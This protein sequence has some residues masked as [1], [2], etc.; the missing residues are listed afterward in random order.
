MKT[1]APRASLRSFAKLG[2]AGL[3]AS[4]AVP[5]FAQ[6]TPPA[7]ATPATPAASAPASPSDDDVLQLDKFV[8]TG[9]S[10]PTE[11]LDSPVVVT[12]FSESY[13]K[14]LNPQSITELAWSIPGF[15]PEDSGGDVG[16]NIAPRGF[17]LSTQME[18]T[19]IQRDGMAVFY[20]QD[21]LFTQSDRF[22]RTS[23]FVQE[24][25]AVRS[26]PS[27][28]FMGSAPAGI[29][30]LISREGG[31]TT[32]GDL[33]F[34]TNTNNRFGFDGWVSGSFDA[35]TTYALGGWYRSD[36]S[37]RD[38]GFTANQGGELNAALKR[39]FQHGRGSFK[40]DLNYQNDE[41][42]FFL[43]M[44]L[45][46]TTS[47]PRTIPG[48]P[49]LKDGT[50]G[51]SS[52]GR[53]LRLANTPSG[54]L[55]FDLQNG[56]SAKVFYV[57]TEFTY[58]LGGGWTVKNQNRYSD[59]E[60]GFDAIINV[61]NARPLT[62]IA[63]E[64]YNSAPARFAGAKNDAGKLFF[65]V[66]ETSSGAV[67][68]NQDS[69]GALNTNGFGIDGGWFHRTLDATN[70]QNDFRLQ[71]TVGDLN[72]TFGVFFSDVDGQVIDHRLDTLQTVSPRPVRADI[73]FLRPDGAALTDDPATAVRE[74]GT[75][76]F[77][78]LLGGP[79]GFGNAIYNERNLAL[80]TDWNYKLGRFNLNLGARWEQLDADGAIE[81]Q[82]S[83][84]LS[85]DGT[86]ND[87]GN[88]ALTN[89]PFG[90]GKFRD[91]DLSYDR[92]A[93]TAAANY[94]LTD[95][96]AVFARYA[97]GFRMPD[98]DKFMAIGGFD[99]STPAGA[100]AIRDFNNSKRPETK[101]AETNIVDVGFKYRSR[102]L[103]TSI[104]GFYAEAKNLFFNVPTVV[105]GQIVQRQAFRNT[106]TYGG[107]AEVS[108][109]PTAGWN[110]SFNATWQDP[111]FKSTPPQEA[112][113]ASGQTVRVNLNGNVPVRTSKFF[114][115][116][117]TSYTF[118][119]SS[120]GTPTIYASVSHT[121]KRYADDANTAALSNYQLVGAGIS[122]ET[123]RGLYFRAD[124]HNL[125]ESKGLSEGDPRAGETIFGG[126]ATFNARAV[127]PRVFTFR[128]GYR[129]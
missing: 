124:V 85:N 41:A 117:R 103:S 116:A 49:S 32:H 40:V 14:R 61:G 102:R 62:S 72:A 123:K 65:Q 119:E 100:Q 125:L 57:G 80:Y 77:D 94:R 25:E 96:L 95:R 67:L 9:V 56:Q 16:N 64:I 33:S 82:G 10:K 19:A 120:L 97:R 88:P 91:F 34:D 127:V 27:S 118:P 69:A 129:F 109:Q 98:V 28:I 53:F 99:G 107:E 21:V 76:T 84:D 6:S 5:V 90:T 47:N 54:D 114:G 43:P 2:L 30:N 78:G 35:N 79:S 126:T 58:D 8:V 112:I 122:L 86:R 37:G 29:I 7:P 108:L 73:V 17:P 106:E 111:Q 31:E 22:T 55:D 66:R 38:P 36:D 3:L 93:W 4:L 105:N 45:T 68:A 60:T 104:T 101:P 75:G 39:T 50:T 113:D 48:G 26:G 52:G 42:I 51:N 23:G 18:F 44:P 46:G 20:D 15:H 11:K 110:L 63:N 89:L 13:L 92:L 83:F 87:A 74:A 115:Q 71:K 128:T 12:T 1:A 59:V 70:F 24:I 81:E 121:G